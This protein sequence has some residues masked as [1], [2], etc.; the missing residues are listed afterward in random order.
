M[1]KIY[2]QV[3][4][5]TPF[6]AIEPGVVIVSEGKILYAGP[7]SQA[8]VVEG[9]EINLDG[10]ILAP[11]YIDI[12]VHGGM[13]ISFGSS[14]DA[15]DELRR[16]SKWATRTGVTGYITS[17]AAS[18]RQALLALVKAYAASMTVMEKEDDDIWRVLI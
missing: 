17:L 16:Y 14:D 7:T 3:R 5:F 11:G 2:S 8:P 1:T 15:L 9:Q 6:L 12:H 4:L 13:G 10:R 18:D